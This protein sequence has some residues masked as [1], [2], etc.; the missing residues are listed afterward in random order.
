MAGAPIDWLCSSEWPY[1]V[2]MMA[3][4]RRL[5]GFKKEY[6]MLEGPARGGDSKGRVGRGDGM[7]LIKTHSIHA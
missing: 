1:T 5:N 7:G 3:V 6:T 4:A 2:L